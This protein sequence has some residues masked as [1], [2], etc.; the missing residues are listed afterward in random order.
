MLENELDKFEFG[1]YEFKLKK[2]R[3]SKSIEI[4]NLELIPEEFLRI[5]KEADKNAIKK[6][7]EET[8]VLISGTNYIEKTGEPTL[9]IKS[10]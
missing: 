6:Y 2:G 7:V 8:G 3:K 4:E 1:N 10:K 9:E 5:K